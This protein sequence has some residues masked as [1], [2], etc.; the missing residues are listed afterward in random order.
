MTPKTIEQYFEVDPA[1]Y[2]RTARGIRVSSFLFMENT[3]ANYNITVHK[4][5]GQRVPSLIEQYAIVFRNETRCQ[6]LQPLH[7]YIKT[8]RKSAKVL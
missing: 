5:R 2:T 8:T 4:L 7:F 3:W 1:Y 6:I